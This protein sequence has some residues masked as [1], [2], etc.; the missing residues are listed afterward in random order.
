MTEEEFDEAMMAHE[1]IIVGKLE[2]GEISVNQALFLDKKLSEW[3]DNFYEE[4][5]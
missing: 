4:A 3:Q 2:K 5:D 1:N